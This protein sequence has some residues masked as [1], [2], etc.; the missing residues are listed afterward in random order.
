LDRTE[1]AVVVQLANLGL[2]SEVDLSNAVHQAQERYRRVTR[3]DP[4]TPF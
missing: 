3:P 4:E 1:N 2:L